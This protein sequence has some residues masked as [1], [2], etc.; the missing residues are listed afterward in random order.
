MSVRLRRL[1]ADYEKMCSLFTGD[2]RIKV[3]KT[4][5]SPAEKYQIE[6]LVTSLQ[7]SLQSQRTENP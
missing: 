3:L 7:N 5:G 6:Y 2:S 4:L 1:K